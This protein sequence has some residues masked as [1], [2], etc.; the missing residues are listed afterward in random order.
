M[1]NSLKTKLDIIRSYKKGVKGRGLP[2]VTKE[3]G[4]SVETLQG[5]IKKRAE[6]ESALVNNGVE[7]RKAKGLAGGGRPAKYEEL[8]VQMRSW[9]KQK[10]SKDITFKDQLFDKKF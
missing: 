5:W 10:Y 3:H 1:N 7:T 2:A 9:I 4:L 6:L 8:E